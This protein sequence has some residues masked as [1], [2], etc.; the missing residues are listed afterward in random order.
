MCIKT[1]NERELD[2]Q[3]D[4][5]SDEGNQTTPFIFSISPSK[6]ILMESW[7]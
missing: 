3:D 5:N 4:D 1:T 6:Y 7:K 2:K